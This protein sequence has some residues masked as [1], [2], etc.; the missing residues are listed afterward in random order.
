MT[1]PLQLILPATNDAPALARRAVERYDANLPRDVLDTLRL[2]VSEIVTNAV[3]HA[4]MHEGGRVRLSVERC[5][6]RVRVEI[7]DSGRGFDPPAEPEP[8]ETGGGF[9]LY[10][11]RR[12]AARWGVARNELTRVWF[13]LAVP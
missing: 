5:A 8:R 1:G 2:L 13:E 9:G 3:R 6:G 11:V 10:L 12:T 7:A 4:H